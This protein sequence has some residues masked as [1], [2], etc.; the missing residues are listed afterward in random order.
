MADIMYEEKSKIVS[1]LFD[2]LKITRA[3]NDIVS[4][5]YHYR[6]GLETVTIKFRGGIEKDID[7]SCDSGIAMI[8]D[9]LRKL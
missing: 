1:A 3:G 5:T 6:T 4:M 9:I 7:V 8:R 2:C